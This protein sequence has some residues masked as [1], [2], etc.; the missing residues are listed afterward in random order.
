[1]PEIACVCFVH[2]DQP[3]LLEHS[4]WLFWLKEV[5][6]YPSRTILNVLQYHMLTPSGCTSHRW[7]LNLSVT[8]IAIHRYD[9]ILSLCCKTTFQGSLFLC[10]GLNPPTDGGEKKKKRDKWKCL[11]FKKICNLLL[12]FQIY[13]LNWSLAKEGD[14]S[15]LNG[16]RKLLW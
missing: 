10:P 1:M 2:W 9:S 4:P 15:K 7:H 13:I 5:I 12:C 8:I 14:L 3:F 11:D 6:I 16:Q